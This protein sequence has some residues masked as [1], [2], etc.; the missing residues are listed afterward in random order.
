MLHV[1]PRC[2]SLRLSTLDASK[3]I[4]F[5]YVLQKYRKPVSQ[6]LN[7]FTLAPHGLHCLKW[8]LSQLLRR[9]AQL[10]PLVHLHSFP[11]KQSNTA[12]KRIVLTSAEVFWY[13]RV[14]IFFFAISPVL[15]PSFSFIFDPV[16]NFSHP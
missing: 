13:S 5:K 3:R 4:T 7:L 11:N 12:R 9:V 16:P 14:C 2:N 1:A 10:R 8:V 6:K 15:P